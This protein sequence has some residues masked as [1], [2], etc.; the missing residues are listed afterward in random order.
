MAIVCLH[1]ARVFRLSVKAAREESVGT[2]WPGPLPATPAAK[3][4]ELLFTLLDALPY[5]I[6]PWGKK[7]W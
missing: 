6:R 1:S 4:M 3:H 7:E 2:P 5:I